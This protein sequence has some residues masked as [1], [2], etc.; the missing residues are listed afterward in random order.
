MQFPNDFIP[1]LDE[2]YFPTTMTS[3]NRNRSMSVIAILRQLS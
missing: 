2:A 3:R 1:K